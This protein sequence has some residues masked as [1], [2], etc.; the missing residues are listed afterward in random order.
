M[1]SETPIGVFD[2]GAGGVSVLRA[3]VR[4]LPRESFIYLGDSAHAPYGSKSAEEVLA[5]SRKMV[6]SLIEE[7]AKAIVIACNTATSAAAAALRHELDIPVIGVEPA[8][9]PAVCAHEGGRILVMATPVTLALDKYHELA[10]RLEARAEVVPIP[11]P[12]LAARVEQGALDA[13]DVEE[14]IRGY[15]GAYAGKADAVVLGCTHYPFVASTIEKVLG[16]VELFDGAEGTARQ[17]ARVLA[18]KSLLKEESLPGDANE[19]GSIVFEST[20]PGAEALYRELF[21]L[22]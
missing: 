1:S 5:L 21:A 12:G 7:G 3:L 22:A 4:E 8:L 10:H 14:L 20:L 17:L 2:S 6:A 16:D 19:Q 9:K 18:Q 13:P 11:C 15:V